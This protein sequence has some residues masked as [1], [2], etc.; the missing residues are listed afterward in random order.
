M[1]D[2][3]SSIRLS[4]A[5]IPSEN[6]TSFFNPTDTVK[7]AVYLR[8]ERRCWLCNEEYK[9]ILEVA[10]NVDAFVPIQKLRNW[11]ELEML[12]RSFY[13]GHASNLILLCSNCHGGYDSD[14]PAWLMLP[15]NLK[16][17]I[18]FEE[19][20]YNER[21]AAARR[22]VSKER[23]LP[24]LGNVGLL[25]KPYFLDSEFAWGRIVDLSEFPKRYDGNPQALVL[26]ASPALVGN[27]PGDQ[28]TNLLG[29]T[30]NLGIPE[31]VF[32]DA[33]N[34]VSLWRRKA[35]EV[36]KQISKRH[37]DP[38][39]DSSSGDVKSLTKVSPRVLRIAAT[40]EAS[41]RALLKTVA[42]LETIVAQSS[43]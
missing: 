26:K 4:S 32:K 18:D 14:Y 15:Q 8:E 20:D 16:L 22:G 13:P 7:S 42:T 39:T 29:K 5:R 27:P 34:L 33:V 35:P 2:T 17:F 28:I 12:P 30:I 1:E 23:S 25:C 24:N 31:D 3:R 21:V 19:Q 9:P 11:K 37:Q 36:N 41:P 6:A 43:T 40:L 10:H 38:G